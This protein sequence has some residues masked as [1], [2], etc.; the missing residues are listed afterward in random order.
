MTVQKRTHA[1]AFKEEVIPKALG[2]LNPRNIKDVTIFSVLK[3]AYE[4]IYQLIENTIKFRDGKSA[5]IIGPRGIG[6]TCLVEYA[7]NVLENEKKF[8]FFTIRIH[9][10]IFRDDAKAIKEIARQLDWYLA[11]YNPEERQRL[12]R[13]TFNQGTVM[14]T[15]NVI[16]DILDRT[17]LSEEIED[18]KLSGEHK[19]QKS[20][21]FVPIVFIIDEIDK[22]THSTKQTLL[23]NLFDMAQS[24]SRVGSKKGTTITVIGLS[25]KTGVRE[26]LEKRVK[27]RFSQRIIQINKVND[28]G[29]FCDCI[30]EMV[31]LEGP[32]E[33]AKLYNDFMK[34]AIYEKG[35]L[36]KQIAQNFY[37]VKDLNGIRNELIIFIM[38]KC[39]D[40]IYQ[41][42]R[43]YSN[44]NTTI[45]KCLSDSELKLLICCCRSKIKNNVSQINFDMAFEEYKSMVLKERREIQS[46]IQVAGMSLNDN[47]DT[48]LLD[49][50]AT[51]ICWERLCDLGLL[52]R[53][54]VSFYGTSA[55]IAQT[56]RG[57]EPTSKRNAM[58]RGMG[59]SSISTTTASYA[60]AA[61][62]MSPSGVSLCSVELDDIVLENVGQSDNDE[63][64]GDSARQEWMSRWCRLG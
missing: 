5:I 32:F 13:A 14:S 54:H 55:A 12:K 21:L 41:H 56:T 62:A 50:D 45:M 8:E 6:K 36:R 53:Q 64:H 9:G 48:Y 24:S 20:H 38:N 27:S 17:K 59:L 40:A 3:P 11:K 30:Y 37:T 51:Q 52:E 33:D 2:K 19:H 34:K 57:E 61:G 26:Q 29:S 39:K 28:L 35:E 60:N 18:E 4:Q 49:R 15:M 46:K 42:M 23:Y 43:D 31:K 22:Y 44:R 16:I 25:T 63:G 10:S 1:E 58:N 47:E 7:I